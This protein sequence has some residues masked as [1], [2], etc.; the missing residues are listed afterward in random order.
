MFQLITAL[1]LLFRDRSKA[2]YKLSRRLVQVFACNRLMNGS[3]SDPSHS[4]ASPSSKDR[5]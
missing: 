4:E 3:Q 1:K 2:E 5:F